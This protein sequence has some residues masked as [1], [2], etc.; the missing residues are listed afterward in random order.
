M[1]CLKSTFSL[2]GKSETMRWPWCRPCRCGV[3]VAT[4]PFLFC[5]KPRSSANTSTGSFERSY[6]KAAERRLLK[7][8]QR[9]FSNRG[10]VHR[11]ER[12]GR[13]RCRFHVSRIG[14]FLC[15]TRPC[16]WIATPCPYCAVTLLSLMWNCYPLLSA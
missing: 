3:M 7:S 15:P 6:R 2:L 4:G 12:T 1:S 11:S 8:R 14:F 5:D 10:G 16:R 13:A 9:T